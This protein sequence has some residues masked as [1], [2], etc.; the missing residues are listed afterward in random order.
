MIK[1][2][3]ANPR[4]NVKRAKTDKDGYARFAVPGN[5]DYTVEAEYH[6]FKRTR[7][8]RYISGVR[9]HLLPPMCNLDF[10]FRVPS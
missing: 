3:R 10:A 7:A 6:G 4:V 5:V 9:P 8:N 1:A 2:E